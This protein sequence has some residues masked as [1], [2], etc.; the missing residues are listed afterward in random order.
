MKAI[1]L[2]FKTSVRCGEA[3]LGLESVSEIIHSD[4]LFGAIANA[5]AILNEDIEEFVGKVRNAELRL[6]SCYPFNGDTFYLPT[7]HLPF[8]GK[9]KRFI[10]LEKFETILSGADLRETE[11]EGE[12]E[13]YKYEVPK[14]SLDRITGN[15]NIYYL[16]AL[17]FKDGAGMYFIVDGS[18]REVE[19][20]L[21]YLRDEGIGGKRTWGLGKFEY[22]ICDFD[23]RTDG[24][25]FVT[26]SLTYPTDPNS[27][28]Y[29][30]PVVRGGWIQS[31]GAS[32]RKPK[33]IMA[34]EG[35]V[36]SRE[37]GGEVIDLYEEINLTSRTDHK[38]YV[39]GKS[40]LIP[41]TLEVE[42]E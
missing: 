24:D 18:L 16:S 35:S 22:E 34:S 10:S 20:A 39:N 31:K 9:M 30:K 6:S 41:A 13:S 5:L 2:H 1:K 38:V 32:Y 21:R 11:G 26:L 7:P 23:I 33:I 17:R 40:F 4:T 27:V 19:T 14:V 28:K 15:S 29:W 3:G 36:F 37:E 8:E 25:Y 42:S 12:I